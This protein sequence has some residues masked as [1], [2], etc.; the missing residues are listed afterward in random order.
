MLS[1]PPAESS[2]E[3]ALYIDNE[4]LF[5]AHLAADRQASD[6][7]AVGIAKFAEDSE[8]LWTLLRAE[9]ELAPEDL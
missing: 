6:N 3:P 8:A 7:L 5:R 4:Q 2:D 1:P 9:L